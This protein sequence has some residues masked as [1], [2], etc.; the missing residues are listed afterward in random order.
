L[1]QFTRLI[2]QSLPNPSLQGSLQ[3]TNE[4]IKGYLDVMKEIFGLV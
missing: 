1:N 2:E 3:R 4:D